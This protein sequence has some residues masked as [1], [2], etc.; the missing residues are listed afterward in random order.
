MIPTYPRTEFMADCARQR[1]AFQT[2]KPFP[3]AVFDGFLSHDCLT[4]ALAEFP[5]VEPDSM[6]VYQNVFEKKRALDQLDSLPDSIQDILLDLNGASFLRCL[7][8]L[9]GIS[10]LIPDPYYRGAGVHVVEPG[11]KLDIHLDF[12]VHPELNL[13][14]R[15]NVILFLNPDW[16][17]EYG[18]HL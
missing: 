17:E 16:R 1:V 2:A 5:L 13:H 11:G 9:S 14:R 3:H 8:E 7:Q 18:G 15:L 12:N 4:Q 10:G 6:Y